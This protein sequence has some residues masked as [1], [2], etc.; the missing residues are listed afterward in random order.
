MGVLVMTMMA[1]HATAQTAAMRGFVVDDEGGE[2][3]QGVNVI[4]QNASGD[5]L[6]TAT[7]PEGFYIIPRIPPDRY[8]LQ[9]S[10]IG[11]DTVRDTLELITG[12]TLTRNIRLRQTAETTVPATPTALA[13]SGPLAG[14]TRSA[15]STNARRKTSYMSCRKPFPEFAR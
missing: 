1:P 6:G 12:E 10:F 3:L 7:D 11:F 2:A 5:V 4:L 15:S 13:S 9:V 8:F 14:S